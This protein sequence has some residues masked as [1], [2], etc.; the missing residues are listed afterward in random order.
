MC[1]SFLLSHCSVLPAFHVSAAS[2][3]EWCRAAS[4]PWFYISCSLM[5]RRMGLVAMGTAHVVPPCPPPASRSD[6]LLLGE[7]SIN[8][9]QIRTAICWSHTYSN[10]IECCAK[11]LIPLLRKHEVSCLIQPLLSHNA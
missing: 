10:T 11:P 9:S 4:S 7:F 8:P 1:N 5:Q 3:I 6:T 2:L